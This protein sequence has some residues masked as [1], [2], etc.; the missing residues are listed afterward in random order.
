LPLW[1]LLFS[2]FFEYHSGFPFSA[3]NDQQ[4][5][6]GPANSFRYPSYVSLNVGRKRPVLTVCT[7]CE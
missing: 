1:D 4:Q 5:L 6:V 3:I 7:N 2:Y